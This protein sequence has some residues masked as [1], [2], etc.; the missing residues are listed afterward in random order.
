MQTLSHPSKITTAA[1]LTRAGRILLALL[2]LRLADDAGDPEV[3]GLRTG[4]RASGTYQDARLVVTSLHDA[5]RYLEAS[6]LHRGAEL[7]RDE[8]S[9]FG[10]EVR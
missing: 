6:G 9:S 2:C 3:G 7:A 5:A 8:A 4:I 10:S 1:L